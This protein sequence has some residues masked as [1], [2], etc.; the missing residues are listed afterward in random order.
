PRRVLFDAGAPAA[1]SAAATLA[2]EYDVQP[3]AVDGGAESVVLTGAG[4]TAAAAERTRLIGIVDAAAP[5]PWPATWY[6]LVPAGAAL[7]LNGQSVAGHV[8]LTGTIVNLA[9]AYEPP[10]G[11]PFQINRW[12]D[13]HSRYRTKSML[14]VPMRTPQGEMLGALQLINCKPE[15]IGP[16]RSPE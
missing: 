2:D 9:D 14:V 1:A 11:S 5:G 15:G 3:W 13:E 8:A 10:P 6:G 12:F 16:L 4:G 7:P